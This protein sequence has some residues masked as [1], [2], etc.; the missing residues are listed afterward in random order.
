MTPFRIAIAQD[1]LDDLRRRL[2]DTR[3]PDQLPGTGWEAGVPL[4]YLKDLATYWGTDY[5][6][7]AQEARLNEFAQFTTVVDGQTVHFL[8]VRSPEPQALP[9]VITHGWPGSVVEFMKILGPLTDAGR[10]G[11]A[12]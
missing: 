2:A 8:H 6:W 1:R 5:D 11:G 9:L 3:W 12:P 10:Q 7:R 4:D